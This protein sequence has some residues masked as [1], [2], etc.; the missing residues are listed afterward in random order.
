MIIE[1]RAAMEMRVLGIPEFESLD[2]EK[3]EQS[4]GPAYD[5]Q[6]RNYVGRVKDCNLS[7]DDCGSHPGNFWCYC[8]REQ[9]GRCVKDVSTPQ[10]W[11]KHMKH[12]KNNLDRRMLTVNYQFFGRILNNGYHGDGHV[13]IAAVCSP[14]KAEAVKGVELQMK[15]CEDF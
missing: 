11:L 13:R 9:W 8:A 6:I 2:L 7:K 15:V 3:M 10:D 5:N 1:Y 12:M 4:L 14:Q